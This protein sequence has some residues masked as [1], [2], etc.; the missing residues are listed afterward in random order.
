MNFTSAKTKPEQSK[1]SF[2]PSPHITAVALECATA[3]FGVFH[4]SF[5]LKR[6]SKGPLDAGRGIPA[7]PPCWPP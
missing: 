4:L 5:L 3:R 1:G 2:A 7:W 6:E